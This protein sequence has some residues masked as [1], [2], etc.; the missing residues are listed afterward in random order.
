MPLKKSLG[1]NF[2]IDNLVIWD[3]LDAID[4]RSNDVL[5]EVGAGSGAVTTELAG[6]AA[7]VYAVEFDEDLIPELTSNLEQFSNVDI[8]PADILRFLEDYDHVKSLGITKIVGSIPYQITSP[9][10]HLAL[11]Y[12]YPVIFVVQ[13]EMAERLTAKPPKANYLS[14]F[15]SLWGQAEIVRTIDRNSFNPVPGVDSAI[16]KIVPHPVVSSVDPVA[17]SKFLHKGFSNPRK[18]L[19]KVFNKDLLTSLDIDPMRRAETLTLS[20]WLKLFD[21]EIGTRA[22]HAQPLQ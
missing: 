15:V 17:F 5:L 12:N 1:Q 13:K 2:L 7:K 19:N 8:V 4:V 20:E 18:M 3:L 10:I 22:E 21:I 16:L 11:K 14:T 9:L 6:R